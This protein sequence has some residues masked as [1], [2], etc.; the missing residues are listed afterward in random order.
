MRSLW[1][2][3]SV[4][5][6][7]FAAG[8]IVWA[9]RNPTVGVVISAATFG[10][11]CVAFVVR[12]LGTVE[13]RLLLAIDPALAK[14]IARLDPN[15]TT[16]ELMR[17]AAKSFL[18]RV[19]ELEHG[20][21]SIEKTELFD[22]M[23]AVA[24]FATRTIHSVDLIPLEDWESPQLKKLLVIQRKQARR[25]RVKMI[26]IRIVDEARLEDP[27]YQR[28]L[29]NYF[30]AQSEARIEV[31]FCRSSLLKD[32]RLDKIDPGGW[33]L[34]DRHEPSRTKGTYSIITENVLRGCWVL[35]RDT[36]ET[37]VRSAAFDVLLEASKTETPLVLAT[38]Q[39]GA[40]AERDLPAGLVRRVEEAALA[41]GAKTPQPGKGQAKGS[42]TK[43][44]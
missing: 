23:C 9:L 20:R 12:R 18:E 28:L 33:M 2:Q 35:L 4:A 41:T 13:E 19:G 34:V 10:L 37:R 26:R 8:I 25:R 7:G 1:L 32:P 15:S 22:A 6:L 14:F 36:T 24:R 38:I 42:K 21:A 30:V 11:S 31:R 43:A 3:L 5:C 29:W 44:T 27:Q 39:Q 17:S 16:A 40:P